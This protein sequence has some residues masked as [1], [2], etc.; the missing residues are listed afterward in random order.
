MNGFTF[1]GIHCSTYGIYYIPDNEDQWFK[2]P[3]FTVYEED[4]KWAP[5]GYPYGREVKIRTF[6]LK[7]YFDCIDLATRERIRR[8]LRRDAYGK[9][10]FDEYPFVYYLV[11]PSKPV[12]GKIYIDTNGAYS[13][14]FNITFTAYMPFGYMTRKYN[15]GSEDDHAEYYCGIIPQSLMPAAPETNRISFMVYNPGTER[16]GM[17]LRVSG[18]ASH[19]IMFAN[20]T[21][22]TMCVINEFP[23]N[24]LIVDVDGE[25]G[26]VTTYLASNPSNKDNGF[27]YHDRGVIRL[28]PNETRTDIPYTYLGP[29]GTLKM[30]RLTGYEM[31]SRLIGG[32]ILFNNSTGLIAH[33]QSVNQASQYAN[34]VLEGI[35]TLPQFGTSVV[36]TM[37]NIQILENQGGNSWG[38]P[39]TLSLNS[40]EIDYLPKM[41]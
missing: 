33:V 6:E 1:D 27:A 30:I 4:I 7:C 26:L 35:G 2:D 11:R 8:W 18:S 13:G 41:L 15:T 14:T 5:G 34:C 39:T 37:N 3:D 12:P 25:T 36:S 29:N 38:S 20:Q 40:I 32:R 19:P 28:E 17:T 31:D 10:V 16:C 22:N 21:N 9:L 23:S 24:N